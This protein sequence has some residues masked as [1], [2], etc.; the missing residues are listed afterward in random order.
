MST[1]ST[2]R[3]L[4]IGIIGYGWL[5]SRIGDR[6]RIKNNIYATTTSEMKQKALIEKGLSSVVVDFN[7]RGSTDGISCWAAVSLLDV[8]IITAPMSTRK[9]KDEKDVQNRIQNLFGFIGHF[10]KQ[11]FFM[12]STSIYPDSLKEF[13]EDDA[14][15]ET[16]FHENLMREL[17]P[18]LNILRLGG[19][20]G[21]DRQLSNYKLSN[22][23]APVNH[24][25]FRDIVSIIEKM[26][27]S[28]SKRKVY[29]VVAP[30]HPSKIEVISEQKNEGSEQGA[31][32][33]GRTISPERLINDLSY[34]FIYPDPRYFHV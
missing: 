26:I 18:Q 24:V 6:L 10:E 34:K 23:N 1:L 28:G 31:Y 2:R 5:G 15:V 4:N 13:H 14:P 16:T 21:D 11:M 30:Q 17:Y 32:A 27:E 33:S 22:L 3:S 20:M 7:S 19:L 9:D 8:L 12:D 29:N 25:H